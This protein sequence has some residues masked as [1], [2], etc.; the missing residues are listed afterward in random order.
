MGERRG[1]KGERKQRL[2]GMKKEGKRGLGAFLC[3]AERL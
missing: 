1:N 3:I 2:W